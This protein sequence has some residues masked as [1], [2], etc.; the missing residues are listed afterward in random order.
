MLVRQILEQGDKDGD[1]KLSKAEFSPGQRLGLINWIQK[2]P[3]ISPSNSS[4]SGSR[5]FCRNRRASAPATVH[6]AC[7]LADPVAPSRPLCFPPPT[8]TKMVRSRAR[9]GRQTFKSGSPIGIHLYSGSLTEESLRNDLFRCCHGAASAALDKEP[10]LEAGS[11][12]G[13]EVRGCV[14]GGGAPINGVELDPL[15]AAG[16]ESKPLI[17]KLLAVPSLRARYLAC[18]RDI[19]NQWLDWDKL[20]PI[21]QRYQALIAAG[22]QDR[23]AQARPDRRLLQ[24][25]H[26]RC[27][28]QRLWPRRRRDDWPKEPPRARG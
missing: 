11:G 4:S 5:P 17:S 6:R 23:H 26:R 24:R 20:G 3:A 2:R 28:R 18:V 10:W 19:A 9:N 21:A 27:P 8:A 16:D 7:V 12:G 25:T 22:Y 15:Y 14:L 13:D 1:H